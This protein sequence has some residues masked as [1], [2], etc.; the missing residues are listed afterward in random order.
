MLPQGN[1]SHP[2][3]TGANHAPQRTGR[4]KPRQPAIKYT[5]TLH[6]FHI[7]SDRVKL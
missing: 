5:E 3:S 2:A 1:A 6:R 4:G 7:L